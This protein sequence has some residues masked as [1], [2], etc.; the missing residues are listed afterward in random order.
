MK[1]TEGMP[2]A[3]LAS[4]LGYN[5]DA[6][7][8]S[9]SAMK[10]KQDYGLVNGSIIHGTTRHTAEFAIY[11][12]VDGDVDKAREHYEAVG[13]K[14]GKKGELYLRS[15]IHDAP[16]P[17]DNAL[18]LLLSTMLGSEETGILQ[19][20]EKTRGKSGN[21]FTW[22]SASSDEIDIAENAVMGIYHCLKAGRRLGK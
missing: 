18:M 14:C 2:E 22:K 17:S 9:Q 11:S 7:E 13:E 1:K 12:F 15:V 10:R 21:L 3:L 4:L 8:I 6:D 5:H 16:D 20:L 19:E